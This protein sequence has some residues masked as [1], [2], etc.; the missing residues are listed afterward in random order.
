MSSELSLAGQNDGL[1]IARASEIERGEGPPATEAELKELAERKARM[2]GSPYWQRFEERAE[3]TAKQWAVVK[4]I[5]E[6][7]PPS[8]KR[9]LGI[10]DGQGSFRA[11]CPETH[12]CHHARNK[13]RLAPAALGALLAPLAAEASARAV[14]R[15]ALRAQVATTIHHI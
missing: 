12:R 4:P 5:H 14:P 6:S 15:H 10:N 1:T 3:E 9:R 7:A 13:F 11:P 2:Q 8:E